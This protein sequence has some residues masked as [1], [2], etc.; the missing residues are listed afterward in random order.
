MRENR[1]VRSRWGVLARKRVSLAVM[2]ALLVVGGLLAAVLPL[3]WSTRHS[4]SS[5]AVIFSRAS[6]IVGGALELALSCTSGETKIRYTLDGRC[7]GRT[8]GS[9]DYT[10]PIPI[11][12]TTVVRAVA[13]QPGYDPGPIGTRTYLFL[14]D[15]LCQDQKSCR[16][17]GL[18]ETW[19]DTVPDYE[20][21]PDVVG[22]SDR[23]GHEGQTSAAVRQA[24]ESLPAVFIVASPEDLFGPEGIY[25]NST[26]E[27]QDEDRAAS[28]EL[29]LPD[30]REG[31]QVDC[32]IRIHGGASRAHQITKKHSFRVSFKKKYGVGKLNFPLFGERAACRFDA[33]VLR[34]GW[35]DAWTFRSEGSG[36][37]YVRDEFS[38]RL[39]LRMGQ[40]SAH[41]MFAHLFLNGAYW[42]LYNLVE[43]PDASF[44]SSY[45]GGEKG[46]WDV[47]KEGRAIDGSCKTWKTLVDLTER[48]RKGA[49]EQQRTAAYFRT[50][51]MGE[52]GVKRPEWECFLDVDN[53]I[54]YII[55]NC[56]LG[57]NDWPDRNY[58][59]ARRRG[60]GST[61]FKFFVWDAEFT[62]DLHSMPSNVDAWSGVAEPYGN[63]VRSQEF[64]VRFGDRV[65]EHFGHGGSLYVDHTRPDWDPKHPERNA[66][67]ASY[68]EICKEIEQGLIAESARWGDEHRDTPYTRDGQWTRERDRLL[69]DYFPTRSFVVLDQFRDAGLYVD[70]PEIA[71]SGGQMTAETEVTISGKR[72]KIYYT[73]DGS[74]PRA[75]GGE[76]AEKASCYSET[77]PIRLQRSAVV[78]TRLLEQGKWSVL[79]V[80][81]FT[82]E[83]QASRQQRAHPNVAGKRR[84]GGLPRP[85]FA[86]ATRGEYGAMRLHRR[87][88]LTAHGKTRSC[89]ENDGLGRPSYG[90]RIQIMGTG[91]LR[92]G[93]AWVGRSAGQWHPVRQ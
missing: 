38:R 88:D 75:I 69:K 67:A 51:G 86:G 65:Q 30:G 16:R 8:N 27:G 74:D 56:Y 43:R 34:A 15:V 13:L 58:Y 59:T 24:L 47:I 28:V 33:I 53:L 35:N 20:M 21:D 70:G 48:V 17:L 37:Q 79:T 81:S 40:P 23:A 3:R 4:D 19:G 93:L 1:L 82:Y 80:A 76:I 41:G 44:A 14:D 83:P 18:P 62:V 61:G 50:L 5:P 25:T 46:D 55:V 52:D 90:L 29:I 36:A 72:G 54:D 78:K 26:E 68:D 77:E 66:P 92:G 6:G 84:Y 22:P 89:A 39:Q 64:R 2:A 85:S 9:R 42:G 12:H 32:A 91:S 45:L 73:V 10:G 57:T 63:L 7:P 11:R 87:C 49:T 60:H 71:P 31:F